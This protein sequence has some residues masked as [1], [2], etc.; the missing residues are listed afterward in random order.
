[1]FLT[2]QI[3]SVAVP[4]GSLAALWIDWIRNQWTTPQVI[5]HVHQRTG[6]G[7]TRGQARIVLIY[8]GILNPN[9]TANRRIQ[10]EYER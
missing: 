8:F 3:N 2:K 6:N 9:G 4:A 5:Y 10:R 7:Q 1:M